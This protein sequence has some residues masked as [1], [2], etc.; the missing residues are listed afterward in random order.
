MAL[1]DSPRLLV[2]YESSVCLWRVCGLLKSSHSFSC[3]SDMRERNAL[4]LLLSIHSWILDGLR[5]CVCAR[6]VVAAALY[7]MHDSD[8]IQPHFTWTISTS[9]TAVCFALFTT[10]VLLRFISHAPCPLG[11]CLM[12]F[13]SCKIDCEAL[14]QCLAAMK[15]SQCEDRFPSHWFS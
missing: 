4:S 6:A 12:S 5:V 2:W 15:L 7:L 11:S 3:C 8:T 1:V 10:L 13:M 9:E 14:H